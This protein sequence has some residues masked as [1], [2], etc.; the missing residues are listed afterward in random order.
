MVIKY[1]GDFKDLEKYNYHKSNDDAGHQAY[2]KN[3]D[4]GYY[5]AIYE[6]YV[7]LKEQKRKLIEYILN[8]FNSAT[9]E[10]KIV[11]PIG[12]NSIPSTFVYLDIE[13][14]ENKEVQEI[15]KIFNITKLAKGGTLV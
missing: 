5:I 8:N 10:V 7:E 6:E 9:L 15:L 1:I 13:K 3:L 14:I 12:T 11:K 4:Y 2:I